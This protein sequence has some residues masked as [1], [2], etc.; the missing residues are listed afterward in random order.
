MPSPNDVIAEGAEHPH[1]PGPE[2]DPRTLHPVRPELG[3]PPRT[4]SS[5]LTSRGATVPDV[6]IRATSSAA[7]RKVAASAR[8]TGGCRRAPPAHRRARRPRGGRDSGLTV[9]RVRGHQ[10]GRVRVV[11]DARQHRLLGRGE[12]RLDDRLEHQHRVDDPDQPGSVHERSGAGRRPAGG[13]RRSWC[14]AGPSGRR[15]R[16]RRGRP[17]PA[18]AATSG[19]HRPRPSSSRSGRRR[20]TSARSRAASRRSARP[21][22]PR[23]AWPGLAGG[24]AAATA[25]RELMSL[26]HHNDVIS[27]AQWRQSAPVSPSGRVKWL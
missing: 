25:P 24:G 1:R 9:E 11:D 8:A 16:R 21:A 14:G 6:R 22:R 12:E 18:G 19:R 5:A 4:T 27:D 7:T 15:G 26:R 13:W 20:R 3:E 17:G 2:R 10:L 23:P